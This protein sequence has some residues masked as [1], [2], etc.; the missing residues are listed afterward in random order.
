MGSDGRRSPEG[1][2]SG[3]EAQ[4]S[5]IGQAATTCQEG[6]DVGMSNQ[7]MAACVQFEANA[8]D[9]RLNAVWGE[10][11]KLAKR[12]DARDAGYGFKTDR[13]GALLKA[14]RAWI[15]FRDGECA[16]ARDQF[17][18]GSMGIPSAAACR[19]QMTAERAIDI[20]AKRDFMLEGY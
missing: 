16:F 17:G 7:G 3:V 13:A 15:E 18:G 2:P 10:T 4:T 19:L 5:C 20:E 9:A 14:Q 8:W 11:M 1:V 12:D 6:W